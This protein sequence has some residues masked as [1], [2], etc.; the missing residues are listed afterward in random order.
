[1]NSIS[2]ADIQAAMASEEL[3]KNEN[4]IPPHMVDGLNR[5]IEK[6]SEPESFLSS[7]IDNDLKRAVE[8]AD[9]INIH[10]IPTYVFWLFNH[11]PAGSWGYSGAVQEWLDS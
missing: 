4:L 1:M 2:E 11:A 9:Y 10:L 7:I 8:T 6:K 3:W 5:W